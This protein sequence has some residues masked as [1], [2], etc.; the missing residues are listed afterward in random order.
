[1]SSMQLSGFGRGSG[2]SMGSISDIMLTCQCSKTG[3]NRRIF[4]SSPEPK[5]HGELNVYQS[6]RRPC[7]RK[8]FQTSISPQPV[9]Q[10]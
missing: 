8:H 4:I 2:V 10:S 3:V 5:A 7:V 1:M 6:I 9:G